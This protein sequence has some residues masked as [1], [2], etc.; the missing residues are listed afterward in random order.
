VKLTFLGTRGN[1]DARSRRHRR[2]TTLEV[3]YRGRAVVVDWGADWRGR[4]DERRPRAIV[5]THSH[6]DHIGGLADGAPCPIWA[7]EAVWEAMERWPIAERRVARHRKRFEVA[8]IG[9]EAFPVEHSVRAPAVGYRIEAGRVAIFYAPDLYAIEGRKKALKGLHAYVG[10]GATLTRP[11]VRY[12]DSTPVG[13]V[14]IAE[15][16]EWCVEAGVPRF[17]VTHCGKH[18]VAGDERKVGARLRK[19]GEESGVQIEIAHDGMEVLLR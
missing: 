1:I 3:A 16:I 2:H 13:H 5:V 19:M 10:D 12:K 8:G 17:I 7:T 18:I 9:F 11:I 6:P 4:H 15:Q 14:S